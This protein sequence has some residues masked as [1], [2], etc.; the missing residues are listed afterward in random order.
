[1]H[2]LKQRTSRLAR[3]AASLLRLKKELATTK[4]ELAAARAELEAL[5]LEYE[6]RGEVMDRNAEIEV[7]LED[8]LVK[9]RAAREKVRSPLIHRRH[10]H[11]PGTQRL[12][13]TLT[14]TL[15]LTL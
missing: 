4:A 13:L 15:T 7:D 14:L 11:Y 1:M 10:P 12:Y 8:E 6:A 3:A 5:Q 2:K 9:E